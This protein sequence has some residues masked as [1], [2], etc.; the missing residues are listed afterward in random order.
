MESR[1]S[2]GFYRHFFTLAD[3]DNSLYGYVKSEMKENRLSYAM[4][5]NWQKS[6]KKESGKYMALYRIYFN[7][8][9]L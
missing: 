5:G 4:S 7:S 8:T 1:L 3:V 9:C 2:L 6:A